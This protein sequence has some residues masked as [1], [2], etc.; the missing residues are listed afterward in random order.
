MVLFVLIALCGR[1]GG[2]VMGRERGG[3]VWLE[4][5]GR[6][7]DVV[8]KQSIIIFIV[9]VVASV[10]VVNGI[11]LFTNTTRLTN[12]RWARWS[13]GCCGRGGR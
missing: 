3:L 6:V 2:G 8:E 1:S 12:T 5:G 11:I 10:V 9:L 7:C 13:M 4:G